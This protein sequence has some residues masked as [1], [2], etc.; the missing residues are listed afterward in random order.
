M[1]IPIAGTRTSERPVQANVYTTLAGRG[2]WW[3]YLHIL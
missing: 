3:P 2:P 1:A